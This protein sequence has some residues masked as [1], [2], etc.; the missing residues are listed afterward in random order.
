[1]C[2]KKR[3]LDDINSSKRMIFFQHGDNGHS[4]L[5]KSLVMRVPKEEEEI[6]VLKNT[7]NFRVKLE[8]GTSN[9]IL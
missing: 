8:C 6:C 7:P 1:M 4:T 9:M 2:K 3:A 5:L